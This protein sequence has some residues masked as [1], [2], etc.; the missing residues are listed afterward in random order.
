MHPDGPDAAAQDIATSSAASFSVR[1]ALIFLLLLIVAGGVAAAALAADL[2][3]LAELWVLGCI[4]AILTIAFCC[5][6][7]KAFG[8]DEIG[9]RIP[10][11]WAELVYRWLACLV[12]VLLIVVVAMWKT[13]CWGRI[14][15]LLASDYPAAI[16]LSGCTDPTHC[17]TFL[18][19]DSL[20]DCECSNGRLELMPQP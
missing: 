4:L 9:C 17:G 14:P 11:G 18:R 6:V 12:F 13:T 2:V 16:T 15:T 19:S 1:D 7:S 8:P 10:T 3:P 5:K 20:C